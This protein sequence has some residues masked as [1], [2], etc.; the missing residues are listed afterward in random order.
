[1][2]VSKSGS[3]QKSAPAR[4]S[5][6]AP[7]RCYAYALRRAARRVSQIYD[8]EL[9]AYGL[10]V[11]QFGL[12][13][14]VRAHAGAGQPAGGPTVGA[15]A[16][17]MNMDSTTLSRNLRP[18]QRRGL[19]ALET[20]PADR[21]S[22]RLRLTPEGAALLEAASQGWRA[23]Q[24]AVQTQLGATGAANLLAALDGAMARLA[25]SPSGD[26]SRKAKA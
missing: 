10:G 26:I 4:K 8:A 18:L 15:L 3:A 6:A 1:M 22:R 9:A 20:D 17:G 24:S 12:M 25:Q 7:P 5:Q 21:R 11:A 13:Q 16:A 2:T 19:L 14:M 23:A